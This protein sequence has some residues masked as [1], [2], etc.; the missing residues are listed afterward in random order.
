VPFHPLW[1]FATVSNADRW[2]VL[3]AFAWLGIIDLALRVVGF[4]RVIRTAESAPVSAER[5]DADQTIARARRY[6]HWLHIASRYHVVRA[7][8]LQRSV[9]LHYWLRK[10]GLP[11]QL[12]V[13]VRK[14][15]GELKA[16]AWV[17]L[18]GQVIDESPTAVAAFTPLTE[19][20]GH[21]ASRAG[22]GLRF[23]DR[24]LKLDAWEIQ[25]Q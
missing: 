24:P 2:M 16:H 1:R 8:C 19:A 6:A 11:S 5:P 21:Q 14:E 4:Q 25:W 18:Q 7:H 17:E 20:G 12:R 23:P 3:R 15:D 9:V 22:T 10:E 13:G